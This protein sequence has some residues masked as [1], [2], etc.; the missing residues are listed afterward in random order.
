MPD[1]AVVGTHGQPFQVPGAHEGLFGAR[2]RPAARGSE[3]LCGTRELRGRCHVA[4]EYAAG[5]HK[6]RRKIE[7]LSGVEQVQHHGVVGPLPRDIAQ[8]PDA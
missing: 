8:V 7:M 1:H 2:L 3:V 6:A 4:D 5:A